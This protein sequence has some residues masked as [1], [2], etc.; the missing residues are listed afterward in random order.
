A[1]LQKRAQRLDEICGADVRYEVDWDTFADDQQALGNIDRV[2]GYAVQRAVQT[3]CND[4]SR[5][6]AVRGGL[7][8]VRLINV[9]AS[10]AENV[11]LR[12]GVLEIRGEYAEGRTDATSHDAVRLAM[13][14][15]LSAGPSE[16]SARFEKSM[17]IGLDQWRDGIGYDL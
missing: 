1:E 2:S 5:T 15:G 16:A 4:P 6:P 3:I 14:N 9:K 12:D 7:H 10:S 11:T 13:E 8:R 17:V